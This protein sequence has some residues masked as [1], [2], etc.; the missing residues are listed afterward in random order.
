MNRIDRMTAI[1]LLLQERPRTASAIARQFEV[2]RRTILR[3]VQALCEIGVPIVAR[4]GVG[5]GYALPLDY[6]ISPPQLNPRES[7]LLLLALETITRLSDAPFAAER[8]TLLAK[9]RALLPPQQLAEVENLLGSVAIDTPQRHQR[10]PWLDRMIAAA[11]A[12]QWLRIEY[13]SATRLSVM[14][15]LPL[16]ISTQEGFW[17]CRAFAHEPAEERI[18]RIDRIRTVA[19]PELSFT[20]GPMPTATPY[21]H[22][23]HPEVQATL[24]VRGVA[25]VESEPHLGQHIERLPNGDGRLCFRCPPAELAW[26]ARYFASLGAEAQVLE[27]PDLRIAIARH[28][29]QL[30]AQYSE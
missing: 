30:L 12:R 27:P 29:R 2:S 16:H 1:V 10:A 4:E 25:L 11:Q 28:A 7:F 13:Q 3:D 18:F 6:T 21:T 8:S 14:H 9:L 22:P 17:Y 15:I 19:S 23:S 5:G 24:T 20:P 26:Y